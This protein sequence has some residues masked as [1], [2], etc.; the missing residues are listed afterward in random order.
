MRQ[1]N[2]EKKELVVC[3]YILLMIVEIVC[4]MILFHIKQ[5]DYQK[6]TGFY[7]NPNRITVI[8]SKKDKKLL[9]DNSTCYIMNQ[10]RKYKIEED[11]GIILKKDDKN[12]YELLLN[13]KTPNNKKRQDIIEITIPK[14]KKTLWNFIKRIGEGDKYKNY[15]RRKTGKY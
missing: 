14:E 12:Y 3:I 7:T 13:V 6:V 15:K 9:Y 4:L 2:Y 10:K 11:K 8:V 5:L 1:H